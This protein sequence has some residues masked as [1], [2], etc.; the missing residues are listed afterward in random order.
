MPGYLSEFGSLPRMNA[1]NTSASGK[2][3]FAKRFFRWVVFGLVGLVTLIAL[4]YAVI[5]FV[6]RREWVSAQAELRA[7]GEKLTLAELIPPPIPDADNFFA[8]PMWNEWTNL[9]EETLPNLPNGHKS[10]LERLGWKPGMVRLPKEQRQLYVFERAMG[11]DGR[12]A[13]FYKAACNPEQGKLRNLD[14]AA[15]CY[16]EQGMVPAE[17]ASLPSAEAVLQVLEVARPASNEI[18][19]LAARPAARFPILY[20]DGYNASL[21]HIGYLMGIARFLSLRV[22]AEAAAGQGNSAEADVILM[23]RLAETTKTERFLISHL[24]RAAILKIAT[25]SV[26]EGI[27]RGCWNDTQLAEIEQKLAAVDLSHGLADALRGERAAVNDESERGARSGGLF[28]LVKIIAPMAPGSLEEYVVKALCAICPRGWVYSD[29]AF[30]NRSMQRAIECAEASP[31]RDFSTS[32]QVELAAMGEPAIYFHLLARGALP[33]IFG[34]DRNFA[35]TEARLREARIACALERFRLKHGEYPESLAPLAPDFIA[36]LPDDPMTNQAFHY[37]RDAPG[38]FLLWSVG[39]NDTDDGGVPSDA[40]NATVG[41]W[42]WRK[43]IR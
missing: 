19:I 27:E 21:E 17:A 43:A 38:D 10:K 33:G 3:R 39:W 35:E 31:L 12:G 36:A 8:A 18:E 22:S 30:Y 24:V 16:R 26:W 28:D 15:A 23:L 14:Q 5:F 37:R 41:D 34:T 25:S 7:K 2:P 6:G 40:R 32:L 20:E 4:A 29:R 42:I 9:V 13:V 1:P 11:R